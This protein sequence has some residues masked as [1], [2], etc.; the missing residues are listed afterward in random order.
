MRS[1]FKKNDSQDSVS[2]YVRK[3][4]DMLKGSLT[5]DFQILD[6]EQTIGAVSDS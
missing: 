3:V 1:L 6:P 2:Q 5:R 4:H